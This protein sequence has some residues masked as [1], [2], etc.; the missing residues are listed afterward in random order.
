MGRVAGTVELYEDGVWSAS[1]TGWHGAGLLLCQGGCHV[2]Q[3][4]AAGWMVRYGHAWCGMCDMPAW[5][6]LSFIH[7][8]TDTLNFNW[9]RVI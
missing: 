8:H 9:Y 4:I 5:T 3:N 2:G 1:G 7:T 6:V